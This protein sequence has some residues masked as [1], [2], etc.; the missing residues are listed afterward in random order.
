MFVIVI[1][2]CPADAR[3]TSSRTASAWTVALSWAAAFDSF[4]LG[5][6]VP[7][8]PWI[9]TPGVTLISSGVLCADRFTVTRHCPP[10]PAIVPAVL[11]QSLEPGVHWNGPT[12]VKLGLVIVAVPRLVT[13]KITVGESP[14]PAANKPKSA[15]VGLMVSWV[16][17]VP[18][19]AICCVRVRSRGS[20][21]CK[22][23]FCAPSPTVTPGMKRTLIV[24]LIGLLPPRRCESVTP[25][26][27]AS[28]PVATSNW[29]ELGPMM[30]NWR[31]PVSTPPAPAFTVTVCQSDLLLSTMPPNA[32][33]AG[34]EVIVVSAT[35]V[36]CRV[37]VEVTAPAV[38][39]KVA[40]R[41]PIAVGKK[42]YATW[43]VLLPP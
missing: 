41:F 16:R 22:V 24:Q 15:L 8:G 43:H 35:P 27:P 38:S 40:V 3:P 12:T 5:S 32:R 13:V 11:G 17:P 7:V 39:V 1:V 31:V 10:L 42:M 25:Q 23:A 26:L 28:R 14:S 20:T 30:V 2:A 21:T 19:R 33:V 18:V 37:A 4:L 6:P 34:V 29:L 9:T 36:P